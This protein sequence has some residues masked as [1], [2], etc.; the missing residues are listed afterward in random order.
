MKIQVSKLLQTSFKTGWNFSAKMHERV[1]L[2]MHKVTL[3][4]LLEF[5]FGDPQKIILLIFGT[6]F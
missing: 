6:L 5:G 3:E 4:A 2:T 1:F